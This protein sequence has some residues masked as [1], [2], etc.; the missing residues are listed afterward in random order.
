MTDC[1]SPIRSMFWAPSA[2]QKSS[3]TAWEAELSITLHASWT[4]DFH[5]N[6]CRLPHVSFDSHVLPLGLRELRRAKPS[7]PGSLCRSMS[8]RLRTDFSTVTGVQGASHCPAGQSGHE[9]QYHA[10][11][12]GHSDWMRCTAW[13]DAL[14]RRR[15]LGIVTVRKA[16]S[17]LWGYSVILLERGPWPC[18]QILPGFGSSMCLE[19]AL[20]RLHERSFDVERAGGLRSSD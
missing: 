17:N 9:S 20:R 19:L 13:H 3:I 1:G 2:A 7:K 4:Q 12:N 8:G 11:V 18:V 6:G 14:S 16:L 10:E 15:S 5:P